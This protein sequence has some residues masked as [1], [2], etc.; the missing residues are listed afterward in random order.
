VERGRSCVWIMI[1]LVLASLPGF[2][3]QADGGFVSRTRSIAVST[4]QRAILVK[5]GDEISMTL[6]TGYTGEGEDFG[7]LI[8]TPVA[9][10][11]QDVREAG[12][13]GETAFEIL[14]KFSA[15][16]IFTYS[17]GTLE[18]ASGQRLSGRQCSPKGTRCLYRTGLGLCRGQ[19]QSN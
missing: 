7:W 8:P 18:L 19:A 6:S 13:N 17:S 4:D 2:R 15:P 10:A 14:D 11:S 12:K 5:Q 16:E 3:A 9:P 1:V